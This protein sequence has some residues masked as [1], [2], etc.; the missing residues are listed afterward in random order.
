MISTKQRSLNIKEGFGPLGSPQKLQQ[1][2]STI[3]DDDLLYLY[4]DALV[5][6]PPAERRTYLQEIANS[7]EHAEKMY[8]SDLECT[9]LIRKE[10]TKRWG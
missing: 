2:L 7:D 1:L 4:I 5:V 3:S 6:L 10:K 8:Q 9:A